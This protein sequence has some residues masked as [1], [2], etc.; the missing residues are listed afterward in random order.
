MQR[1]DDVLAV[2][3]TGGRAQRL[4]GID[5][6]ALTV[7]GMALRDRVLAAASGCDRVVVGPGPQGDPAIRVVREDP[8]HQGPVAGLAR[9]VEEAGPQIRRVLVLGGDM[10][11]IDRDLVAWL[12]ATD[13]S[14]AVRSVVDGE[15]HVQFLCSVWPVDLLRQALTQLA[16][17]DGAQL[18]PQAV[19]GCSMKRLYARV[20]VVS[21][22]TVTDRIRDVDTPKDA[23]ELGAQ[24]AGDISNRYAATTDNAATTE[25]D[26]PEHRRHSDQEPDS[27]PQRVTDRKPARD[28]RLDR[29]VYRDQGIHL[30]RDTHRD[31]ERHLDRKRH[32]DTECHRDRDPAVD[33]D[34]AR[35]IESDATRTGALRVALAQ[36]EV[37]EDFG[38]TIAR[39]A[40]AAAR[41]AK[42][43]A[44]LLVLP[45]AT[46][47]PF[48]TD[49]Q[50]AAHE[51]SARFD[52]HITELAAR[53]GLV[54]V[55]GSF[56]PGEQGRVRNELIVR[57]MRTQLSYRKIHL[58]DA[59]GA[60]ESD[61][62]EP[63]RDLVTFDLGGLRIGIAICYDLRFPDQ[64]IALAEAGA[65]AVILS[66]A[67]ADGP[68]KADQWRTLTSAR[69]MDATVW[70]LACDQAP[71]QDDSGHK[72]EHRSVPRGVGLSRCVDPSGSVR[73][74]LGREPGLLVVDIDTQEVERVRT[75]LPVLRHRKRML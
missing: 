14:D 64:F 19:S 23:R 51:D 72:G 6:T 39:I 35:R 31:R 60:K 41:A 33:C 34:S 27:V 30:D 55:A 67:W 40:E 29:D 12:L 63:G 68:S 45:E 25:T 46:L 43:Q 5:K 1:Y 52:R 69:A 36:I 17:P 26:R 57:G 37:S 59:R 9:G 21:L 16:R 42:Q 4:D 32:L 65:D 58:Y 61:T 66:A 48:G 3:L 71:P 62:V 8:P 13:D 15:G 49:L 11:L 53:Y 44:R 18:T 50:R 10:P 56:T 28:F 73:A 24:E 75:S 47:T 2:I 20:P 22:G 7:G 74:E 54:I 70:L 38:A